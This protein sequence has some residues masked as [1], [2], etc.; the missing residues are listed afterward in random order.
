VVRHQLAAELNRLHV[1]PSCID[2][3]ILVASELV[4]NAVRHTPPVSASRLRVSWDLEP[5]SL[6]IRVEDG[7][8][9]SPRKRAPGERQP[10]GRGLAIV[11][12]LAADWGVEPTNLG[13]QVWARVP[14]HE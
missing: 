11:E 13:K 1:D 8:P 12:A 3:A 6:M 10:D 7:S 9:E 14:I 4:A 2:D 5:Q